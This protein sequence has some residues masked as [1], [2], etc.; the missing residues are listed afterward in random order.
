L[1][2]LTRFDPLT[3]DKLESLD[4]VTIFPAKQFVTPGE[5]MKR[6]ILSIRGIANGE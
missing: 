1:I 2:R 6:A 3:G 4:L 5:K